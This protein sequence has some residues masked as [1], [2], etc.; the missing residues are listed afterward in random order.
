MAEQAL[1]L[2]SIFASEVLELMTTLKCS[3]ETTL[4]INSPKSV[5]SDHSTSISVFDDSSGGTLLNEISK[6]C[7]V[8]AS[9]AAIRLL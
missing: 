5:A 7:R 3:S 4:L 8:E 9:E 1:S 2:A 6:F